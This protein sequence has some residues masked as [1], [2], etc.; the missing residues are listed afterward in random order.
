MNGCFTD[1]ELHPMKLLEKRKLRP[2]KHAPHFSCVCVCKHVFM[3]FLIFQMSINRKIRKIDAAKRFGWLQNDQRRWK[4]LHVPVSITD[5]LA[6]IQTHSLY[7]IELL[8]ILRKQN[9]T[10]R[11]T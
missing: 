3:A 7:S 11:F 8:S 4:Y 1:F 9:I 5:I 10:V 2:A 6:L